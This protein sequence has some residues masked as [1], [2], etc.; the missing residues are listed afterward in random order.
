MARLRLILLSAAFLVAGAEPAQACRCPQQPL[1]RYFER[2]E[3]VVV[4]RV[5][6]VKAV[7]TEGGARFEIGVAPQFRPE[8]T[9]KGSMDGMVLATP[10]SS[11]AC[12]VDVK[13]GEVYVIFAAR[14]DVAQPQLAWFNTC[15]GSRRYPSNDPKEGPAFIGIENR[16]VLLRLFELDQ[17]AKTSSQTPP[18]EAPPL[19]GPIA[20]LPAPPISRPA[21]GEAAGLAKI[22]RRDMAYLDEDWDGRVFSEPKGRRYVTSSL[23]GRLGREEYPANVTEVRRIGADVWLHVEVFARSPCYDP[24]ERPA[25]T[26][27]IPAFSARG[28]LTASTYPGGC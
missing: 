4:G 16:H 3:I 22:E 2:A 8:P 18:P 10:Q 28:R 5:T 24:N 20:E 9:F 21:P 15:S 13:V 7:E 25:Q 14:S 12:G 23:K 17:A 27:W 6:A 11:A 26:G 19:E 1:E